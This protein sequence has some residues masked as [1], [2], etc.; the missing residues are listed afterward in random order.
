MQTSKP[1]FAICAV[2]LCASALGLIAQDNPAQAKAREA[3]LQKMRELDAQQAAPPAQQPQ[4]LDAVVPA[5]G[6]AKAP[7]TATAPKPAVVAPARAKTTPAPVAPKPVVT[8]PPTTVM[9]QAG[10]VF[11]P[12]P[13]PSDEQ[14][15]ARAREALR[16]KMSELDTQPTAPL[17]AV[18]PAVK[19]APATPAPSSKASDAEKKRADAEAAKAQKE[20]AEAERKRAAAEAKERKEAE[21]AALVEAQKT[22]KQ[23]SSEAASGF[24]PIEAPALPI[25]AEKQALLAELLRKY[26]ADEIT[27]EE[28][29]KQK[30]KILADQ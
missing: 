6:P 5:P 1:I 29:F 11:A 27:P 23:L 25:S 28:Y 15:T 17:T 14:A 26:K 16:Q 22:K 7:P 3:L 2:A 24:K 4:P 30:V 9:T 13:P 19:P 20:A 18:V 10:A 12:V 21:K 8:T